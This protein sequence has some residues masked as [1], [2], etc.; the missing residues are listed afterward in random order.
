MTSGTAKNH[1]KAGEFY[2]IIL[3]L[4]VLINNQLNYNH[5]NHGI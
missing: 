1:W 5:Q 2:I 3:H 4:C